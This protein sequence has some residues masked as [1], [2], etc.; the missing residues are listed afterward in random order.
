MDP[1]FEMFQP[2]FEVEI[3]N[4]DHYLSHLTKNDLG[5]ELAE[6]SRAHSQSL[7]G[8]KKGWLRDLTDMMMSHVIKEVTRRIG[9]EG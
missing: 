8:K 4:Y 3:R 5:N 7:F 9:R 1:V 2:L 6:I